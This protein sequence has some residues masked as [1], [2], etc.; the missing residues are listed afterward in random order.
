MLSQCKDAKDNP[1]AL[2]ARMTRIARMIYMLSQC[3]DAK[4]NPAV[5]MARIELNYSEFH[6]RMAQI[7]R[8]N[9][10]SKQKMFKRPT[11]REKRHSH[12]V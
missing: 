7:S 3:K 9:G 1:A 12:L 6:A 10:T 2:F 11:S 5:R 4:D 8:T